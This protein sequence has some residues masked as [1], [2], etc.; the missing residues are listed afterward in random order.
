MALRLLDLPNTLGVLQGVVM[1]L[2]DCGF[3]Q[4]KGKVGGNIGCSSDCCCRFFL[5]GARDG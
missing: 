5:R 1:E 2:E 3:A 4:M